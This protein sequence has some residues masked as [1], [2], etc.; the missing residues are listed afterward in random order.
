LDGSVGVA[1]AIGIVVGAV[2]GDSVMVGLGVI[3]GVRVAVAVGDGVYVGVGGSVGVLLG[4]RF[5]VG[6]N[7]ER[8]EA[9]TCVADGSNVA[10]KDCCS[11]V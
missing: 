3:V 7:V 2:V 8:W 4:A 10:A 1:E 6:T 11:A 9:C 5:A